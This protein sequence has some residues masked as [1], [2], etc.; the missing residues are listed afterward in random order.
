MSRKSYRT[1]TS[2]PPV[3]PPV[4]AR[5]YT[6]RT[7]RTAPARVDYTTFTSETQY[8]HVRQ[9]LLRIGLLALCLFGSLVLLRVVT[10]ALGLLP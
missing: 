8:V 4:P 10:A 9:D 7:A 2:R 3:D 1:G 5:R 6:P